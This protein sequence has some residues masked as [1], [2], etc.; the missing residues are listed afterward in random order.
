M[1]GFSDA[2]KV[3][4]LK[5]TFPDVWRDQLVQQADNGIEGGRGVRKYP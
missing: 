3:K 1:T 4:I 5:K 2:P